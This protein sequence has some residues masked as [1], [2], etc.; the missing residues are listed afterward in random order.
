MREEW[1]RLETPKTFAEGLLQTVRFPSVSV[2]I[3][4]AW[5]D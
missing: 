3:A 5:P 2:N 4:P 1:L